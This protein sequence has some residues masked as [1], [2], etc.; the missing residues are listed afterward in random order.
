MWEASSAVEGHYQQLVCSYLG[1]A[2]TV[3]GNRAWWGTR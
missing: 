3:T 2:R 1:M